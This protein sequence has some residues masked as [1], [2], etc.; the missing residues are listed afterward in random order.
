MVQAD[1]KIVV[2]GY[3]T[4]VNPNNFLGTAN[5][6]FALVRLNADGSLDTS[7]G[8]GGKVTTDFVGRDNSAVGVVL[9]SSGNLVAA[10]STFDTDPTQA[11]GLVR[12]PCRRWQRG[13]PSAA[14]FAASA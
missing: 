12:Y 7:F 13:L 14:A 8:S 6:D 1:G 5:K 11:F 2:A 9:Q 4:V 10:G 3:A